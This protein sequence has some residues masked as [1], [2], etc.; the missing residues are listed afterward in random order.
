MPNYSFH[1]QS[2]SC[3]NVFWLLGHFSYQYRIFFSTFLRI[4]N[5]EYW[6]ST[7]YPF[8]NVSGRIPSR[9]PPCSRGLLLSTEASLTV[10]KCTFF[11]S[12]DV[13]PVLATQ[14]FV[15]ASNCII[16]CKQIPFQIQQS[17]LQLIVWAWQCVWCGQKS[18]LKLISFL[19]KK[20]QCWA[21][22]LFEKE[23][24]WWDQSK[25][26]K[27]NNFFPVQTRLCV[28]LVS[29]QYPCWICHQILES[30]LSQQ[31]TVLLLGS[32]RVAKFLAFFENYLPKWR[33]TWFPKFAFLS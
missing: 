20:N 28:A 5:F 27:C 17:L 24:L 29:T 2:H 23:A 7:T 14:A 13:F 1:S 6:T 8:L 25:Q 15:L 12:S 10:Y 31:K 33:I 4:R 19:E 26:L 18:Q 22:W 11:F 16:R 32:F 9:G 30:L 3:N 21:L